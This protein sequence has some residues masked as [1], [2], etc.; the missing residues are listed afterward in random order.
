M[1]KRYELKPCPF[2]G[3]RAKI[4]ATPSINLMPHYFATC[5]SCGAEMPR[6]YRTKEA[7]AEPWN[8]RVSNG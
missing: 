2:C 1:E 6:V 7:A 8:R 5:L 4:L 3:G